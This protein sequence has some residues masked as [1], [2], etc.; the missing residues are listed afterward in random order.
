MQTL[1]WF[2]AAG[3]LVVS[4][5]TIGLAASALIHRSDMSP[6]EDLMVALGGSIGIT[7]LAAVAQLPLH[8]AYVTVSPPLMIL[9]LA[10]S[11]LILR[12]RRAWLR[13]MA[14]DG[15]VHLMA[16]S[17]G[18]LF[19]MGLTVGALPWDNPA[20]GS[21][22]TIGSF[23]A[24]DMPGDT[25]LQ[26]RTAEIIQNRL[27]IQ[28]T[29][30]YADYWFISDRTPLVGF[31]T[32]FVASSA[33]IH[34]PKTLDPLSA[35]YQ[36]VD[37]FGYWLYRQL[38]MFT[39]A[40]VVAS[41]ILVAW[42]LLGP[43]AARLGA[44]F[45]VLSPFVLIDIVFH[46]PKLLVGFFVAGFYFWSYV[47]RRP[48]LAGV[49]AA[50]AVLSHPVGALFLPG[51][52]LY[53]LLTRRWRQLLTTGAFAAVVAFPW[54]FWTSVIY[55]HTSRML[56]Y[57]IGYALNDPTNPGP[58]IRADL[59]AFLH[60]PIGSILNDRWICLRD[61]FTT[62]PFPRTLISE[63]NV[64]KLGTALYEVFRTTF[65]GVFGLGLAIF[66]YAS[67][68]RITGQAFWAATL[69]AST[70]CVFLFW[71]FTPRAVA[72]EAFQPISALWICLA[73]S[74]LAAFPAWIIRSIVLFSAIE[75]LAFT[76]FLL[77]Q[78]PSLSQWRVSWFLLVA[79]NLALVAS[80]AVAG[81]K[82][83]SEKRGETGRGPTPPE[84]ASIKAP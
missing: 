29:P 68:K 70:I 73:A 75:W 40:L 46:W 19:A 38:S 26:Y 34:L 65:P 53:L 24:P 64:Q 63:R 15:Q 58:E 36:V 50:A 49:F 11:V 56:T 52:F 45:V 4:L 43:R 1:I 81:W 77:L 39:N 55:H 31:A 69:G 62:W 72:Q 7:A 41:A 30:F 37:P 82:A 16:M 28:S 17:A 6:G 78:T 3:V 10:A 14:K 51:M 54:F 12:R 66:G 61:T 20:D 18:A 25:L 22:G 2:L 9:L 44:V 76:Y 67:W 23:H 21:A 84:L 8:L 80:V 32:T 59:L 13:T 60:R 42:E 74:V 48:V 71:G 79:I 33:G 83:A 27:P 57:P 5:L 35:P 47:R